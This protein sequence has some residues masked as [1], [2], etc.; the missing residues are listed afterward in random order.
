MTD[1][2]SIH[3]IIHLFKHF[4]F[5]PDSENWKYLTIKGACFGTPD[6]EYNVMPTGEIGE[7]HVQIAPLGDPLAY[8]F[9]IV[10]FNDGKTHLYQQNSD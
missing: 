9:G 5:A 3:H 8:K 10:F 1:T 2:S 4:R 7:F 6:V